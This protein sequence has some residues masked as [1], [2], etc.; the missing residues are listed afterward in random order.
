MAP[1]NEAEGAMSMDDVWGLLIGIGLLA[2]VIGYL[3]N[4]YR[5]PESFRWLDLPLPERK[6]APYSA[7][8]SGNSNVPTTSTMMLSGRPRR[9]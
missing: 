3:T 5:H 9:Q 2:T 6:D 1:S 7:Q 4:V 8:A